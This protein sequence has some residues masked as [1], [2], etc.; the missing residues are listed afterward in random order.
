MTVL[1]FHKCE[2]SIDSS[3]VPSDELAH[4]AFK[5][6]QEFA[7]AFERR[8]QTEGATLRYVTVKPV[9]TEKLLRFL[10]EEEGLFRLEFEATPSIVS[11]RDK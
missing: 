3:G 8:F 4:A 7:E 1:P 9:A 6:V 10:R 5:A 11:G 2:V